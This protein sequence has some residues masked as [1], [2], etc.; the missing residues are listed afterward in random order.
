MAGLSVYV[1]VGLRSG[2]GEE[3]GMVSRGVGR[4]VGDGVGPGVG[5]RVRTGFRVGLHTRQQNHGERVWC[6]AKALVGRGLVGGGPEGG[7]GR[8]DSGKGRGELGR[9]SGRGGGG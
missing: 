4:A 3:G 2:V 9:E 7:G 1:Y 6:D 8:L 5:R